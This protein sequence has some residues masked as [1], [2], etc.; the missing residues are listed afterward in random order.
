ML[1]FL[2]R[3]TR[4]PTPG[5]GDKPRVRE[6]SGDAKEAEL[7]RRVTQRDQRAFETLYRIYHPRLVR[8]MS[9][10]TAR[11]TIVEEALNDTMLVVWNRAH[12]FNGQCKVS[13]WIFAIAYRTVCK[14]LRWQDTPVDPVDMDERASDDA[15]P[16]GMNNAREMQAALARALDCL[17]HEHRNVVVLTYFHDLPYA[18]IA[19]IMDCP[20]DTVKTRMFHARR[21]LRVLLQDELGDMP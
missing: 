1:G 13:T 12:T 2:Q 18:E 21:K 5:G 9:L 19:Q 17:S 10:V 6:T 3:L 4:T 11:S 7:I 16:E 15:G 8:F 14:S 20:V